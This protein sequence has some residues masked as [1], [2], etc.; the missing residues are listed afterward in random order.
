MSSVDIYFH[1]LVKREPIATQVAH[2]TTAIMQHFYFVSRRALRLQLSGLRDLMGGNTA[3]PTEIAELIS[4]DPRT[5]TSHLHIDPVLRTFICCT[6]CHS[7]YPYNPNEPSNP[8][9]CLGRRAPESSPCAAE[10]W[11]ET[12]VGGRQRIV[13]CVLYQH[14]DF[15]HWLARILARKGIDDLL[16]S[17][18]SELRSGHQ[19][20]SDI[21]L[22]NIF[23]Q[24]KGHD[25]N[26][27][28]G[29]GRLVFGLSADSFEPNA[30]R[31]GHTPQSS[32]GIWLVCYN[33]P[34]HLRYL[35]ENIYL[36]GVIP[37]P[38]KPSLD[39]INPYIQ[40]IVDDFLQFWESGVFFS[41]THG[42]ASG[43][44]YF[45]AL[46]PLVCDM[47]GARQVAGKPAPSAHNTCTVCDIDIDDI[48][49]L[50]PLKWPSKSGQH[51]RDAAKA[52]RDAPSERHKK[53]LFEAFGQRWSPLFDLPYWDPV[54]F[55][56]IDS[57]HALDINLLKNHLRYMF[58][59][60]TSNPGGNATPI[61]PSVRDKMA[62]NKRLTKTL[63]DCKKLVASKPPN[64]LFKLL[65]LH[66]KVLYV[67]CMEMG[68][69][70]ANGEVLGTRW[71][72]AQ[73]IHR[74]VRNY[75]RMLTCEY[76]LL[77]PS[78]V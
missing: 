38:K 16:D 63:T 10:L 57:M 32:T 28:S 30:S 62:L 76:Q 33:L 46:I 8:P 72:L 2:V 7:I 67:F 18:P 22:A 73:G 64:L 66:R 13:P 69:V 21:W 6:S 25:G 31:P 59:I 78:E 42:S 54:K 70:G 37:G 68:V 29:P 61:V 17:Y 49:V 19:P 47:L 35:P 53:M 34:P 44:T 41:R 43:R 12:I 51:L 14:Q 71:V 48:D 20:I 77:T 24:L 27:F 60:D 1:S 39:E 52:W 50:D 40:L 74:W 23:S 5:A 15:K 45:A 3:V 56:V 26:L 75:N 58:Q 9:R 36:A 55:I 11:K 65:E 4:G